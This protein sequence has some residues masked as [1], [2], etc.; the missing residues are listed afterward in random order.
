MERLEVAIA[1]ADRVRDAVCAALD[2][3][4]PLKNTMLSHAYLA[5]SL[6][7]LSGYCDVLCL[8]R[9]RCFAALQTGNIVHIGI[10]LSRWYD[11]DGKTLMA[12][13]LFNGAV[14][15]SHMAA[16][17]GFCAIADRMRRPVQVAAPLLGALTLVGG[18]VDGF[19]GNQWAACFLAASFGAM[20]FASSPNTPLE[21]RLFT[22]T[23]LATGNLQ[24]CC[25]VQ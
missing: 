7:I 25:T 8:L 18:L 24:K 1:P 19:T 23:S 9:F 14:L 4:L 11:D 13:L 12:T 17:F 16:V 10:A 2:E 20:N 3:S 6:A 21:G 15:A 5:G 22:M